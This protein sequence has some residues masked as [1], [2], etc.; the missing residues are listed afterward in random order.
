MNRNQKLRLNTISS[1]VSKFTI[2]LS[3][4]ILP[5]LILSNYG[6]EINGLVNSVTQFLSVI[7]FLDLG[8]G[9]VVQSALYRPLSQGNN[10]EIS[11]IVSS[12]KKY[13]RNIALT[14]LIYVLLLVLI[15]PQTIEISNLDII[16]TMFLIIAISIDQ[17]GRYYL[18][19]VNE[20]LLNADQKAYIQLGTE[21]I[22]VLLNLIISII[23]ILNGSEIYTVKFVSGLIYLIRPLYLTY[24]VKNNYSINMNTTSSKD[25]LPQKWNGMAQHIAYSIQNSTDI[26]VLTI[27]ST[28]ENISI[29]SIYNMIVNAMK[30][31]I[32]SFTIGL[33]SFFGGILAEEEYNTLRNLFSKIEW[34][35]HN[36]TVFLYSI[37]AVLI[38]DFVMIYTTGVNDVNYVAPLFSVFL[39][40]GA[41]IYSIRTPYQAIV[42][43]AGHFKQTQFSSIIEA[44]IN[45]I[46]SIILV[47]Y[48][49]L[50]GVAIGSF[51]AMIYRT[52][53]L[54]NYL[55]HNILN[56]NKIVVLRQF[57]IDILA[58]G[59]ITVPGIIIISMY[60]INNL[61][62]WIIA[63]ILLAFYSLVV[64]LIIN[65]IFYKTR[66]IDTFKH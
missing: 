46:L 7:T 3:G 30:M 58:T 8:V 14:L 60:N 54:I 65:I 41:F 13:F 44:G 37:C 1:L 66:L 19:I 15:Y 6:S 57:F 42:F 59:L 25:A 9:T 51:V 50:A 2:L 16:G 43:A 10:Q 31:V 38:T 11:N 49:G 35:I 27:F 33:Q 26:V 45:I 17:F 62:Q 63:A 52:A 24:Y 12:A 4:L 56:L 28:L 39:I 21:V 23:L 20:L 34:G 18:G 36:I 22:V 47:N 32:Q 53:Y 64:L 5:R 55:S 48:L 40:L 29:Y 61:V